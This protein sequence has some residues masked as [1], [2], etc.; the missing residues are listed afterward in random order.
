M[1]ITVTDKTGIRHEGLGHLEYGNEYDVPDHLGAFFV[2][3]GWAEDENGN[4]GERGSLDYNDPTNPATVAKLM[5]KT[6]VQG[7]KTIKPKD[8]KHQAKRG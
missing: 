1:K 8:G 3:N 4:S 2:A 7:Q 6:L 5:N